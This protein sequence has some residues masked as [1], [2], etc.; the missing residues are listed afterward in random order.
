[1]T[2]YNSR[3]AEVINYADPAEKVRLIDVVDAT[4]TYVGEANVGISEATDSWTVKKITSSAG[5]LT[6]IRIAYGAWTDRA[7]L[8]Y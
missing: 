2:A 5:E 7:S 8:T 6:G 4:L 3:G 1:M